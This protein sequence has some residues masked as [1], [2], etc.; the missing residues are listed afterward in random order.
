MVEE[1]AINPTLPLRTYF[2]GLQNLLV[3]PITPRGIIL[4]TSNS[5]QRSAMW[6]VHQK[7]TLVFRSMAGFDRVL[8]DSTPLSL[9][10]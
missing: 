6:V 2:S 3:A 1:C 4:S 5:L 8:L 7:L 9:S 10:E